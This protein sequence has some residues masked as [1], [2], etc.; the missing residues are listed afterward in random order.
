MVNFVYNT[1]MKHF[2]V[3]LISNLRNYKLLYSSD[4]GLF[5]RYTTQ[6]QKVTPVQAYLRP[7]ATQLSL[8]RPTDGSILIDKLANII[9]RSDKQSFPIMIN[10]SGAALPHN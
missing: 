10:N 8:L 4:W 9:Y 7:E 1:V 5:C 6:G 2:P 3:I